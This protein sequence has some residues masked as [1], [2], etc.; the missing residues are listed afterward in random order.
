M[1]DGR[2]KVTRY[3]ADFIV[4]TNDGLDSPA[5]RKIIA[6]NGVEYWMRNSQEPGRLSVQVLFLSEDIQS[7][8]DI[9]RE[10]LNHFLNIISYITTRR[11]EYESLLKVID[12]TPGI[13]ERSALVFHNL[14]LDIYTSPTLDLKL[15]ESLSIILN[16]PKSSYFSNALYWFRNGI[17][18][19][20][21]AESFQFHWFA[22]E[23]IA[24]NSPSGEK[25]HDN[26]TTCGSNLF[27]QSC[28]EYPKHRPFATQK[29]ERIVRQ[30][31]NE[32]GSRALFAR[33]K[34]VRNAL[35]H[36]RSMT[37]G[38]RKI[39]DD[40]YNIEE[41]DLVNAL[42]YT[43]SEAL[44]HWIPRDDTTPQINLLEPNH[45]FTRTVGSTAIMTLR[46][47]LME[48]GLPEFDECGTFQTYIEIANAI[49]SRNR[50]DS[51]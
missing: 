48:D 36:G 15:L 46:S 17:A 16:L 31:W 7:S 21:L 29:I 41:L 38:L 33:F 12:W 32:E 28:N 24:E 6:A 47:P 2:G 34:S 39:S 49:V 43:V 44:W 20:S 11:Y 37:D 51:N 40:D 10:H 9:A 4:R 23:L 22:L 30:F 8:K 3:I 5:R 25:V 35:M 18:A 50:Q 13:E 14:N 42:G 26:C 19:Q 1:L 45:F 27:C